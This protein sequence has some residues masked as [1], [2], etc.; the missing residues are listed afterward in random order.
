MELNN[1][2]NKGAWSEI[3]AALNQNFLKILAELLKY[4]H[5]TTISGANFL[6]YFT[7]ST[8]L[9]NSAEAAWAVAGNLK[10]VTVYAYYTSDAVPNGFSAGWNALSSLGTYDFTDYSNLLTKVEETDAKVSEL[11]LEIK[12]IRF[13]VSHNYP[14][15]GVDASGNSGGNRYSFDTAIGKVN[16]INRKKGMVID[17]INLEGVWESYEL[18]DDED[19]INYYLKTSWRPIYMSRI[20]PK[21]GTSLD[22][23]LDITFLF[24][25]GGY[26]TNNSTRDIGSFYYLEQ[27]YVSN[28][29]SLV[30]KVHSQDKFTLTNITAGVSSGRAYA[31]Y[32]THGTLL[33][34]AE[35]DTISEVLTIEQDGYVIFNR[36]DDSG[37]LIAN[38]MTIYNDM[39]QG[40]LYGLVSSYGKFIQEVKQ[41]LEMSTTVGNI[42]KAVNEIESMYDLEGNIYSGEHT[43]NGYYI[44]SANGNL[45]TATTLPNAVVS[46]IMPVKGGKVYCISGRVEK[47]A[48]RCL[49]SNGNKIKVLSAS[50]E[51]ELSIGGWN[52]PTPDGSSEAINGQFKTPDNAVSVQFGITL[53]KAFNEANNQ[54]VLELVGDKYD[55]NFVPSQFDGFGAR[56][57]LK[58]EHFP[59]SILE[60]LN[61]S[62]KTFSLR[63]CPLLVISAASHGEGFGS[64]KNKSFIS[65]FS[66]LVDYN[67][68]NYSQ[69]GSNSF[70][71]YNMIMKDVSI[72]GVKPSDLAKRGGYVVIVH[73]GDNEAGYYRNGVDGKYYER[74]IIHECKAWESMGF[75]PILSGY[76]GDQTTPYAAIVQSV[77]KKF[78][79]K[80][81]N[82]NASNSRF[83]RNLYEPWW[84]NA[85]FGTRTC[86]MQ[87]YSLLNVL[88]WVSRPM[89]A[90]KIFKPR[91]SGQSL[92]NLL[93]DNNFERLEKWVELSL[94]HQ[95]LKSGY[96][97]YVDRLDLY[98]SNVNS[99]ESVMSEYAAMRNSGSVTISEKALAHIVL[100]IIGAKSLSI[101]PIVSGNISVYAR[102]YRDISLAI[103][104]GISSALYTLTD[105][106]T[107]KE[108]DTLSDSNNSG[109]TLTVIDI[110]KSTITCTSSAEFTTEGNMTGTLTD[111]NGNTYNYTHL[112]KGPGSNYFTEIVKSIGEWVQLDNVD[113]VYYIEEPGL[114]VDY[115]SLDLCLVGS[116]FALSD[117]EITYSGGIEKDMD[118]SFGKYVL[119]TD[120]FENTNILPICH[121]N[122]PVSDW[123]ASGD[124]TQW[125]GI[126]D[127]G[128]HIPLYYSGKGC[129]SILRLNK[130]AKV[131]QMVGMKGNTDR[132]VKTYKVKIA[133]RYY[134]EEY[135][136]INDAPNNGITPSSFDMGK[137]GISVKLSSDAANT[138]YTDTLYIPA[139]FCELEKEY[140]FD[141]HLSVATDQVLILEA[142]TD[143]IELLYCEVFE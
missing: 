58:K 47:S 125:S 141:Y 120:T 59:A 3:A 51:I 70:N 14:T 95:A 122:S 67:V 84:Y 132:K 19:N 96:E 101:K 82:I 142:L 126:T 10:A 24:A 4:Q 9:P 77:A 116:N 43:D 140:T 35:T 114:F 2:N 86:A 128:S 106:G 36:K 41:L 7:S 111:S 46:E 12:T 139:T 50:T 72:G 27:E 135:S 118:N 104:S 44:N 68:E 69:S 22:M 102:R 103:D 17:F 56:K 13:N 129:Q 143:R 32:N 93:F 73:G 38:R 80:Y 100:P 127:L 31:I 57:V 52:M 49:D 45:N 97:N 74:N 15:N 90:I 5:V 6:G 137:L 91:L 130:G 40:L 33:R 37:S 62:E 131:S 39:T 54:V 85:H 26:I 64:L 16:P 92:D 108:G 121:F 98:K 65:Y 107:I 75:K 34:V 48:I 124:Y 18:L 88:E 110:N 105:A 60:N 83:F 23:N 136:D 138:V 53:Y 20:G 63:D 71:H 134:P 78:G 109:I 112:G 81:I 89:Q 94:H 87:W 42:A 8:L 55:E 76:W 123:N 117:I 61:E 28:W 21:K 1:I 25:P 133:C 113:D 79:Y 115:D 119:N 66:S 99:L 11:G 29:S 30:L